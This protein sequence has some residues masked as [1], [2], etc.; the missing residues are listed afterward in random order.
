M[1]EEI[2]EMTEEVR[3]NATITAKMINDKKQQMIRYIVNDK[4]SLF[5]TG[6]NIKIGI[7]LDKLSRDITNII[8]KYSYNYENE[9]DLI[10]E[11]NKE[12]DEI[13][14][15]NTYSLSI[16]WLNH[17][18]STSAIYGRICWDDYKSIWQQKH[19]NINIFYNLM[20]ENHHRLL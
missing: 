11:H 4:N 5:E 9:L 8:C 6:K 10:I 12:I 14:G 13:I 7:I 20:F 3:H 1:T 19:R 15:K 18:W 17:Y 16:L 2:K